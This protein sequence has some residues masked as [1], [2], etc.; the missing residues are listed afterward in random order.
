MP[1][2]L[3]CCLT[4]SLVLLALAPTP[5]QEQ[6]FEGVATL[7]LVFTNNGEPLPDPLLGKFY[8][9][10]PGKPDHYLGWGH[11][12]R[13]IRVPAGL[14][15]IVIR[16]AND[17]VV[18]RRVLEEFE[19]VGE[20]LLEEEAAFELPEASLTVDII[21]GGSPIPV[22]SGSFSVHR[23]GQRGKPLAAKRPGETVT[24]PP[25]TYDIEV[26]YRDPLGLKSTWLNG[27]HLEGDRYEAV[28]VHWK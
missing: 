9:Y 18:E 5:A 25:G 17:K 20:V 21:S 12:A 1:R 16:Y 13:S 19:L 6:E 8:V 10:E 28:K 22:Y 27:Y 7:T 14:Y 4:S 2:A 3:A 11:A 23:A 24:I 26:V 15:D